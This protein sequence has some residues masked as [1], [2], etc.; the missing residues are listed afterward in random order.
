MTSSTGD[1]KSS[2]NPASPRARKLQ[3]LDVWQITVTKRITRKINK[4]GYLTIT[5]EKARGK[6]MK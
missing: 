1:I 2:S 6:F 5:W 3:S 4:N